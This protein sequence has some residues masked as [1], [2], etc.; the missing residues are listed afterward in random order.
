MGVDLNYLRCWE[1]VVLFAFVLDAFSRRMVG[2]QFAAH[3]R[4]GLVLDALRMALGQR[5]AG[6]HVCLVHHSDSETA[7]V[8][9]GVRLP[10]CGWG[11]V[12]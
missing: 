3:I 5:G 9:L 6:A 11:R 2:W 12:V 8:W 10:W 7:V 4:T 1:G